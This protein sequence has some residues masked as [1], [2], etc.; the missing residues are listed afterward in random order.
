MQQLP[1]T[2]M[3]DSLF[4][5]FFAAVAILS[6]VL[7]IT[8]RNPIH[9]AVFLLTTLLATAGI[10]LQL[11]AEFLFIAQVFLYAG[12]V[13]ILFIFVIMSLRLDV[14]ARRGKVSSLRWISL[15]V[16][17]ALGVQFAAVLWASRRTPGQGIFVREAA[18]AYSLPP[19]SEALA[20]SL[21]GSYLL[22]FEIAGV[23]FLVAMV[24]A[25]LLAK[26]RTEPR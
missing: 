15:S 1:Q 19:N 4:F 10:F 12:G 3:L 22:P 13:M 17:L 8:R 20:E 26:N 2:P 9:S 25:V 7:L 18:P 21:F 14:F 6:A 24:G 11:H 16:A 5:Y 23:L